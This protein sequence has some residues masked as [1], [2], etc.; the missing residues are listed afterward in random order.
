[1]RSRAH[2]DT[3]KATEPG[4]SGDASAQLRGRHV[5]AS[6]PR[7]S[8]SAGASSP[9]DAR[10]TMAVAHR[11]L[12]CRS[13]QR[14]ISDSRQCVR[15]RSKASASA[16]RCGLVA[17]AASR[18]RRTS[19]LACRTGWRACVA[20]R[21]VFPFRALVLIALLG[22]LVLQPVKALLDAPSQLTVTLVSDTS[23]TISW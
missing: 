1:M 12:Q 4:S 15:R 16:S 6:V 14:P 23:V 7:Q 13:G 22:G 20:L 10:N 8:S 3:A 17:A 9:L 5:R 21:H 11:Q 2:T 19:S 18:R